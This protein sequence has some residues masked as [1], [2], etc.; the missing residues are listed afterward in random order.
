GST[1]IAQGM[2][3]GLEILGH[4]VDGLASFDTSCDGSV[5]SHCGRGSA[6]KQVLVVITDG[7]GNT[8]PWDQED[9]PGVPNSPVNCRSVDLFTPNLQPDTGSNRSINRARDCTIH[10]TNQAVNNNVTVFTI[11]LGNGVDT[12]LLELVGDIGKGGYFNA[13]TPAQLDE[14]FELI[15]QNVSVRL[16]Q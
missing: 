14:I 13:A 1:N 15:L 2:R 4:N 3:D 10:Y 16:I 8:N 9:V 12:E 11:G 5:G 6:A 7:V